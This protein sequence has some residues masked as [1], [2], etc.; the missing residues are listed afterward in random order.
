MTLSHYIDDFFLYKVT[1]WMTF[2][3]NYFGIYFSKVL[4][5]IVTL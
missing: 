2:D 3:K 5:N 4:Y 1:I